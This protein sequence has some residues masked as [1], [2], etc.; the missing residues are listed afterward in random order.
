MMQANIYLNFNGTCE[1]AFNHYKAV[2]GGEFR[3]ISRFNEMPPQDGQ[4]ELSEK[5]GN[6]IMHVALP[7]GTHSVIMGSDVGGP[8][9]ALYKE[10]SNFQ[11]SLHLDSKERADAIYAGLAQGGRHNMPMADTFWGAYFGMLTDAFGIQW[12]I[13]VDAMPH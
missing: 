10:G 7:I 3:M 9:T 6:K 4:P 2:L 1:A 12:I 8:W 13:N 5:E 11:I